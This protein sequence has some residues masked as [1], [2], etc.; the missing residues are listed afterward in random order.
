MRKYNIHLLVSICFIVLLILYAY[1]IQL[2]EYTVYWVFSTERAD[3][4]ETDL[5][6]IAYEIWH[7]QD[8]VERVAADHNKR[9]GAPDRLTVRLY[10]S[11]Y[12]LEHGKEFYIRTFE[13]EKSEETRQGSHGF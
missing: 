7:N 1:H 12:N 11:Q 2:P 10:S 4:K 8:M 9:N 3:Y 5:H 6:V 13:Y